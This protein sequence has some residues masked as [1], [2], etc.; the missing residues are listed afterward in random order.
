MRR[1][2][3]SKYHYGRSVY[4][5]SG[6]VI[7]LNAFVLYNL[8]KGNSVGVTFETAMQAIVANVSL[9]L[10]AYDNI[11]LQ[12]SVNKSHTRLNKITKPDDGRI[13]GGQIAPVPVNPSILP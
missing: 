4:I 12:K 2:E 8:F 1:G 6:I 3:K 7:I 13:D 5:K 10:T 11:K 9:I